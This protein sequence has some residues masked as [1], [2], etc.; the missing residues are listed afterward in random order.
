MPYIVGVP[1]DLPLVGVR[2]ERLRPDGLL[3]ATSDPAWQQRSFSYGS[4][5]ER[6]Y[7]IAVHPRSRRKAS[8]RRLGSST[9]C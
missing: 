7:D 5:G 2:G 8:R 9:C 1:V 3:T 6:S 4:K